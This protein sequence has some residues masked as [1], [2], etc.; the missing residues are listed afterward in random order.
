[1]S[2][3]NAEQAR[4]LAEDEEDDGGNGLLGLW[5]TRHWEAVEL[6]GPKSGAASPAEYA[7][8]LPAM[9]KKAP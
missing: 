3:F 7:R 8:L 1:M 6:L 2:A 4:L 5:R 9:N